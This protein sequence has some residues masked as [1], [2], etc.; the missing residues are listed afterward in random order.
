MKIGKAFAGMAAAVLA[1]SMMAM[2]ASATNLFD[3]VDPEKEVP[4]GEKGF[5]DIGAMGFFMNGNWEDWNQSEWCGIQDDGTITVEYEINSIL[6]DKTMNG[7]GSLGMMGIMVLNLPEDGYPYDVTVTEANFTAKDGTVTELDTAKAIT[8]GTRHPESGWRI[9][10]R[11]TDEVDEASGEV[12]TAA[13]PELAGWDEPGKFNGGTLKIT[14]D[15]QKPDKGEESEEESSEESSEEESKAEESAAEESKEEES[16][17]EESTAEESKA[18]ESKAEESKAEETGTTTTGTTAAASTTAVSGSTTAA[19]GSTANN[20]AAA[21]QTAPDQSKGDAS[22]T[23]AAENAA[24][25]V[26]AVAAA[27]VIISKKRM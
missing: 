23:G 1:A 13:A 9:I 27:A 14:V 2:S 4:E 8:Q 7:E 10:L 5:Y 20:T 26:G 18:E 6:A 17:A 16:K 22:K 3:L 11:P 25:A 19:S 12:K 24:L 21:A 15:F